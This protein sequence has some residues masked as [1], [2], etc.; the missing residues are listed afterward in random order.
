MLSLIF[1]FAAFLSAMFVLRAADFDL[2]QNGG[3]TVNEALRLV[4]LGPAAE[5]RD[6][7]YQQLLEHVL[8]RTDEVLDSI[9]VTNANKASWLGYS[10]LCIAAAFLF[11]I[12]AA[13]MQ[14]LRAF[15]CVPA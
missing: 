5:G 10:W 12:L 4:R 6:T 13:S 11:A 3:D 14:L 2:P 1:L 8:I 9:A 15:T 7:R